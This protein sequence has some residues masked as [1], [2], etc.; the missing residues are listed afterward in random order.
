MRAQNKRSMIN[1]DMVIGDAL[2]MMKRQKPSTPS[3]SNAM[4]EATSIMNNLCWNCR[5][6]VNPWSVR[7]LRR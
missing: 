6:M 2:G 1:Y 4:I 7:Q 3:D 5:G